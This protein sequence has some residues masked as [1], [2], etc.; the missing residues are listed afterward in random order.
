MPPLTVLG[1]VVFQRHSLLPQF[2]RNVEGKL[3]RQGRNTTSGKLTTSEL[4]YQERADSLLRYGHVV[5]M[6]EDNKKKKL[7]HIARKVYEI[8]QRITRILEDVE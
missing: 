6:E 1:H 8:D 3:A 5:R 2:S 7:F 4:P